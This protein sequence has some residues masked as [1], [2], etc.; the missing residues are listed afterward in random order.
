MVAEKCSGPTGRASYTATVLDRV[1][2]SECARRGPI[3]T[4]ACACAR[5]SHELAARCWPP[6]RIN[7][8]RRANHH[9]RDIAFGGEGDLTELEHEQPVIATLATERRVH[10]RATRPRNA[11]ENAASAELLPQRI[12]RRR[13]SGLWKPHF[14]ADRSIDAR[15]ALSRRI[16]NAHSVRHHACV[17]RDGARLRP[18]HG[19]LAPDAGCGEHSRV[20]FGKGRGAAGQREQRKVSKEVTHVLKRRGPHRARNGRGSLERRI[21]CWRCPPRR[22]S[23]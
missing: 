4:P 15:M 10:F 1:S 9:V 18:I 14:G 19:L 23:C 7:R 12:R 21:H 3:E 20:P 2:V 8:V 6:A 22:S 11:R 16:E 17:D 5:Q 13:T